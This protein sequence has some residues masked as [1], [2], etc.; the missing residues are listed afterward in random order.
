MTAARVNKAS[1]MKNIVATNSSFIPLTELAKELGVHRT[2]VRRYALKNGFKFSWMRTP[3]SG[4]QLT[5]CLS[6]QD[7]Q[8]LKQ[9]RREQGFAV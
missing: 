7:T 1:A 8:A 9:L 3:D 2:H 6:R 4:C 5:L